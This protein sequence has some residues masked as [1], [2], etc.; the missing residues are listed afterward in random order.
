MDGDD[1]AAP[2]RKERGMRGCVSPA[3]GLRDAA[4]R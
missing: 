4:L 1:A 2:A 3:I